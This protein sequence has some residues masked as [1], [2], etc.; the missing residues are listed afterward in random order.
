[1]NTNR[2]LITKLIIKGG[3]SREWDIQQAR[4]HVCDGQASPKFCPYNAKKDCLCIEYLVCYILISNVY[5]FYQEMMN[6][7]SMPITQL[8]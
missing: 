7:T 1:M 5:I 6:I 3:M 4:I 2:N 8:S